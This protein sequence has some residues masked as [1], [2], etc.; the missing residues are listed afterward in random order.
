MALRVPEEDEK[1]I[2][3]ENP[4]QY[5]QKQG[6]HNSEEG[7]DAEENSEPSVEEQ[8]EVIGQTPSPQ[9][10]KK[11][12]FASISPDGWQLAIACKDN[13]LAVFSL[14]NPTGEYKKSKY[15][16]SSRYK[17][18]ARYTEN[19]KI[20]NMCWSLV[21]SDLHRTLPFYLLPQPIQLSKSTPLLFG[22]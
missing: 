14:I 22:L 21:L 10:K 18:L 11:I 20:V 3:P 12:L 7:E 4:N 2:E 17:T 6:D 19:Y 15:L 8:P 1:L 13:K 16:L 9:Q 5:L